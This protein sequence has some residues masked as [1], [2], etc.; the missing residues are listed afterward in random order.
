M[1][2]ALVGE[3]V[4]SAF[5]RVVFNRVASSDILDYLKRRK[6]ID[7]MV[8]KL[9]IELMSAAAVLIDAEEKQITNPAVKEWLDELKDAV[10]VA[11]DLLDEIA[12]EALRCKLEAESTSKVRGFI[13]TFVNSFDRRIQSELEKV[14]NTLEYITKRK[15]VLC[16]KEVVG[17]VPSRPLTTSCPEE[18]GVFGRDKDKEAIFKKFQSD[19]AS[20]DGI[21]VVPIVGM[22]G[23]GKTTLAR[24]IYNDKRVDNFDHKLGFAFRKILIRVT[25]STCDIQNMDLLQIRIR[26]KFKE[27]KIFLVLDDV[28]NENYGDWVELLKV[29]RCGAQEIQIIIT[30]RSKKVASNVC[31][32]PPYLLKQLSNDEC[33]SLFE[34]HAFKNG[35]ANE[36]QALEE[37]GRQIVQ[38]CKGLPLA[39]KALGGLLRSEQDLREWTKILKSDIWDLP[40][41]NNSILP[42]LRLSYH[43]LP[44]HLKRCFAYC[45]ILPK[46]YEFKKDELVPLWMAEDL[47]LQFKGNERMEEIGEWYFDDLVSRSFFQ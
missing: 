24:F 44:S 36:F 45:S 11:D 19:N 12:Y 43:Y 18:Y 23:V 29:F 26:E 38:K 16:L 6:L 37:I 31:T 5:L 39:A 1:A 2:G 22:G 14:L 4:L 17:R 8:Q 27:K 7:R 25:L 10:Y 35:N 13:S 47:L 40:E 30:T 3:A 9:K 21:C 42:A 15:D 32:I 28:W 33:W 41:G 46:D 20:V 34:K